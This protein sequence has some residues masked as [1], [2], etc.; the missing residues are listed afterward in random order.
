MA[1]GHNEPDNI[2]E[3]RPAKR[4]DMSVVAEMIQVFCFV[5]LYSNLTTIFTLF[6]SFVYIK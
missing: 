2:I 1:E 3:V 5:H 6:N 4:E